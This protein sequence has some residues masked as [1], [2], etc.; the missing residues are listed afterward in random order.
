MAVGFR[1]RTILVVD[2][3]QFIRHIYNKELSQ[4]GYSVLS[5]SSGMEAL[6]KLKEFSIDLILMDAVMPV[7]DGFQTCM[8]IKKDPL[9]KKIPVI[10]LTANSDKDSV[11]KAVQSGGNDFSV[12]SSEFDGL[13]SKIEKHLKNIL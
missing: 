2:D 7:M 9:G 10:F 13:F 11:I 6:E 12:K 4:K 3:Q 1:K 8:K 5:A